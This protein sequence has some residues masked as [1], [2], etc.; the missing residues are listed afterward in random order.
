MTRGSE[1]PLIFVLKGLVPYTHENLLLSFRPSEFFYELEKLSGHSRGSLRAAYGR[2]QRSGLVT[3]DPIPRLTKMGR[4]KL[5]PFVA[6]YLPG[7]GQLLV[8]F[9]IPEA[10]AFAR[11]Q[12]RL[13]LRQLQFE[14]VQQSVWITV[15]DHRQTL[16]EAIK[17]LHLDGCVKMY[18][19]IETS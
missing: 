4:Q 7:K 9:D 12:F 13:L 6:Q 5:Q 10:T 16:T 15:F 8:V 19:A 11:R 2:A 3:C 18:E 17:E 1:S 14:Q